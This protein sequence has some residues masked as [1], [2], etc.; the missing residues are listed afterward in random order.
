M[1]EAQ[2][3]ST[4]DLEVLAP[5]RS[6][7]TLTPDATQLAL[8]DSWTPDAYRC[9]LRLPE[10]LRS[11]CLC[12][13]L[14]VVQAALSCFWGCLCDGS[15]QQ[16]EDCALHLCVRTEILDDHLTRAACANMRKSGL[17]IIRTIALLG[18]RP[19]GSQ[20]VCPQ[21]AAAVDA[22]KQGHIPQLKV[23]T[24]DVII[25]PADGKDR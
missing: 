10:G 19:P 16:L 4:C 24:L 15:M 22:A 23:L 11:V 1:P 13:V 17:S 20:E 6:L 25:A 18:C 7:Q 21:W 5:W 3:K 14:T 8:G 2:R 12:M 9:L